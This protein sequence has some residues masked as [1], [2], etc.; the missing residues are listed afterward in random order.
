MLQHHA[1]H[2][3]HG[4]HDEGEGQH[5]LLVPA[6]TQHGALLRGLPDGRQEGPR[7]GS[8]A[9]LARL[10]GVQHVHSCQ[11]NFGYEDHGDD[12]GG[13]RGGVAG[14]GG[15]G[16]VAGRGGGVAGRGG[17]V[18]GRG[19]GVAGRGGGVVAGRGGGVVAGRVA[20]GGGGGGGD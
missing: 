16:G 12:G 14:R 20:G 2:V 4:D 5:A 8:H 18:A 17:G 1:L 13:G 6:A 9:S 19:G 7:W 3:Q 15:R 11:L 10:P